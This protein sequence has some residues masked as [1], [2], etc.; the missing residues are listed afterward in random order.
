MLI[1]SNAP[2]ATAY[3]PVS[4]YKA[5]KEIKNGKDWAKVTD[6]CGKVNVCLA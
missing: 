1:S 6:G 2:P 4:T 5:L 3:I